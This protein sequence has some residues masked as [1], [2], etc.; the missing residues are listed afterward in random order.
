TITFS[1]KGD[2]L[3]N[4]QFFFDT[5][6][7]FKDLN[8]KQEEAVNCLEGSLLIMAGAGSG[9]TR[10]LTCRIANLIAQGIEPSNI[11]AITFTNKAANEMKS[12]AAKLIGK[13]A[14]DVWLSTF[15]SFCARLLRCEI[16]V[17]GRFTKNF[18]IYDAG[19]TRS[20]VKQCVDE[21]RLGES[22]FANVHLTI[23]NLKN[24][25]I[26]PAKYREKN[27]FG[28][29]PYTINVA[30]IYEL[31]QKKLQENNA[32]DFDDLIFATVKLF[33]EFPDVLDKY[34]ERF[35]YILIDEYQDTNAA[36]YALT[37]LLAAK[38]RNLCVVGDADQSIY[39]W[40]GADMRNILNFERDYPEAHIVLLEQ[41]YRST[42]TILNAANSVIQNNIDRKPKNLWTQNGGGEKIKFVTLESDLQEA[43]VVAKEIKRLVGREELN[44]NDIAILYRT[45]AQSRLFEERF[46]N[47]EIP[48]LIVGGLKFYDR[49]EIK[50]I[51]AYLHVIA[52]PRDDLHL[53]RIINVPKR[54]LGI[55]NINRLAAFAS[56]NQISILEVVSDKKLLMQVPEIN[57]RF[58]AGLQDFAAMIMSFSESANNL[59]VDKLITT[60]LNESG[61]LKMLRET[62]EEGKR[63]NVSREENLG[64]FVDSAKEFGEMNPGGTLEDFLNHVALITDLD[65]L[66]EEKDA[67]VKL[68]TVHA[69]KGL[70]FKVVFVVGMEDGLFPH[71]NAIN[72]R[73]ALEEE[74]RACYVALTRA[75]TKLY[76]TA[77]ESRMF[78]GKRRDQDVSRF[79]AE[80][81]DDCVESFGI[82]AKPPQKK[83]P[84]KST[85]K[86]PAAHRSAQNKKPAK[87]ISAPAPRT[88]WQVGDK[89]NHRKWGMGT[90]M[91]V[92][93]E[94]MTVSFANPEVGTKKLVIIAAPI[95]KV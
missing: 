62:M 87:K 88:V 1:L 85:Y 39:G 31:Y 45:N 26:D 33:R 12:R 80:I 68:M 93:K 7:I 56:Q 61:Y 81:P 63:D 53:R 64:A 36:Q 46:I 74:R 69:A 44:Y 67:R 71:V 49:K 29:N 8:P 27:F 84:P 78:F 95:N 55:T 32:L 59:P 91:E 35:K 48:Y 75:K 16:E 28:G 20:L 70:E 66:D 2:A 38:Y 18:A 19:D 17:T 58:R 50:D 21:L 60:V 54:G 72:D 10:V 11:L 82:K 9:K 89:L 51:L 14:R 25:L 76:I 24:E 42:K 6:K 94:I 41:N 43:F 37:N 47:E 79:A 83:A 57:P 13:P 73:A 65:N 90:V 86:T 3:L 30:K 77:A 34:Q 23:S 52:N 22:I 5:E 15:H 40:R 92:G 4:E